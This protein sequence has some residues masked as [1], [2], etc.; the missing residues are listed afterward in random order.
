MIAT[1]FSQRL[2]AQAAQIGAPRRRLE[3]AW[4]GSLVPSRWIQV[5]A[6]DPTVMAVRDEVMT[7]GVWTE[8]DMSR[9]CSGI[10][11][12]TWQRL[13]PVRESRRRNG[14][15]HRRGDD[16]RDCKSLESVHGCASSYLE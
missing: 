6:G 11:C 12:S 7:R 15:R 4:I 9:P 1:Q 16:E 14:K 2:T 3:A 10:T 13:W 5:N 8:A